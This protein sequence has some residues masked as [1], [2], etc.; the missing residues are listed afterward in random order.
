[1]CPSPGRKSPW[2]Q[3]ERPPKNR[4]AMR[5]SPPPLPPLAAL[6]P[7]LRT[8]LY[9]GG[10]ASSATAC[11]GAAA[12]EGGP[13]PQAPFAGASTAAGAA[14]LIPP[15]GGNSGVNSP[16]FGFI[17]PRCSCYKLLLVE[18][19]IRPPQTPVRF[20]ILIALHELLVQMRKTWTVFAMLAWCDA[21]QPAG[22]KPRDRAAPAMR[23]SESPRLDEALSFTRRML[24]VG[25]AAAALPPRQAAWAVSDATVSKFATQA[26]P[27]AKDSE[28]FTYLD[29][30]VS[31]RCGGVG[32]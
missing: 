6:R 15:G 25:A 28:P 16:A 14:A 10:F 3:R 1:V 32:T 9:L 26:P 20:W 11:A 21:F 24:I 5:P 19:A 30:G 22:V 4:V 27:T 31:Y 23:C 2:A 7:Q 29:S 13:L 12:E 17:S 8:L 18:L